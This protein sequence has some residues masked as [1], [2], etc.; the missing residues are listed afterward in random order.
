MRR[1]AHITQGLE[2]GGQERLLVEM[3]RHRDRARFELRDVH[4]HLAVDGE[5]GYLTG[6][7]IHNDFKD[8]DAWIAKHNRY[9]TL[10][11]GEIARAGGGLRL[12]GRLFG[13]R[14]QRR[15][16]IKDRIWNRL[17]FR[18]LVLFFY[19]YVVRLGFLNGRLGMRF[20]L[21]HAIFDAFTTAKVWEERW[22]RKHPVGNYYREILAREVARHPAERAF[23]PE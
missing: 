12:E 1:V 15:R 2:V 14:V 8:M 13:S 23:Y 17:P 16:W 5:T 3:A 22:V 10:E 20:C 21:M 19:L 4:E 18:P 6:D 11:A 9:A 7:L